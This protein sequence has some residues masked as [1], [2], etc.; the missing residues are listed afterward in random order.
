MLAL[1]LKNYYMII[2]VAIIVYGTRFVNL[3]AYID[4]AIVKFSVALITLYLAHKNPI[5]SIYVLLL[6]FFAYNFTITKD[7]KESFNHIEAFENLEAIDS[8]EYV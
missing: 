4:S 1:E 8:D 7:I 3:S 2:I 5:H 6:Y